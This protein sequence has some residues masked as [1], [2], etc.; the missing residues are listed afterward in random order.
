[1]AAL[2][3]LPALPHTQVGTRASHIATSSRLAAD[4]A[5]LEAERAAR[6]ERAGAAEHELLQML[7]APFNAWGEDVFWQLVM[8]EYALLHLEGVTRSPK[9]MQL[10][11]RSL[12]LKARQEVPRLHGSMQIDA[13]QDA[14]DASTPLRTELLLQ[15]D[16]YKRLYC[17]MMSGFGRFKKLTPGTG[18]SL[19]GLMT[20]TNTDARAWRPPGATPAEKLALVSKENGRYSAEWRTNTWLQRH[21]D[22]GQ[23]LSLRGTAGVTMAG[24]RRLQ[25]LPA[26]EVPKY[27]HP[28]TIR[29]HDLQAHQ[30]QRSKALANT[31]TIK[32]CA[33]QWD[34]VKQLAIGL[35]AKAPD[36]CM[37]A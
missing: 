29:L 7:R 24:L 26:H 23:T 11:F 19:L 37:Y 20:R 10:D 28:T 3:S 17:S 5:E 15:L 36:V 2:A 8:C 35:R 27:E 6:T 9:Q 13:L 25:N 16:R 18:E 30:I 34:E 33:L 4:R 12:C 1:V 14:L 22:T 21:E 31:F 32:R